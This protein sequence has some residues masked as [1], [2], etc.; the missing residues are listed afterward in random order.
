[1]PKVSRGWPKTG[2][3][4]IRTEETSWIFWKEILMGKPFGLYVHI[5]FC[6][7]LCHYCDFA[8]TANFN[9][10]HQ[11]SYIESLIKQLSVWYSVIPDSKR[12]TSVFF[13]GGTPGLLT[14]EYAEL[15]TLIG[16]RAVHDVEV[17]LEANPSNVTEEACEV[18]RSL[19]F[20]RLSVGVQSFDESG[21]KVLTRDH[22]CSEAFSA[23]QKAAKTFPRSNG[24]LIYGWP[25]QTT[26]SWLSDLSRMVDSGVN[27]LSLYALTYEGQ[28]P[29]ARAQR[30][31]VMQAVDDDRLA[32]FYDAACE[33]LRKSGFEHEEI[34]NWSRPGAS[35][36]HNW[37]YWH[38]DEYIGIGAGAHGF[39]AD[40]SNVG[41]RYS[42][43]GDLRS[44]LRTEIQNS[45][46]PEI[47]DIVL[48]TGG[49]V[50]SERTLESWLL[51]Y[52]GCGLRC[53][54]GIDI[55]LIT[56]KGYRLRESEVFRRGLRDGMLRMQNDR[57]YLSESEWFRETAWSLAV[58]DC[59][60]VASI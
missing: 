42:Y 47:K 5:P 24:D 54:D 29:F 36:R 15:M 1:V 57:I 49:I 32:I 4:S 22:S 13:G 44:F 21:L 38:G 16:Q 53:R 14:H 46:G 60:V 27:H 48:S 31:G 50:D 51:E 6:S 2:L 8:K 23:L 43:P 17:T 7:K 35:C 34:S 19:G 56:A 20:N 37:L 10:D 11:K 55:N 9:A 28:T 41:L 18:W 12:F 58:A 45:V 26:D 59:F 30:R 40:G 52:V 3:V 25:G 39:V 33:F